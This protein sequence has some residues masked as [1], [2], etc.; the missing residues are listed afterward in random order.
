M[1]K[2]REERYERFIQRNTNQTKY[3]CGEQDSERAVDCTGGNQYFYRAGILAASD[4]R[5]GA[6]RRLLAVCPEARGRV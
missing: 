2:M 5:C 3:P 1:G 4:R 6:G